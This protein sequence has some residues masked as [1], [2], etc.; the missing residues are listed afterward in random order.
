MSD[1]YQITAAECASK[2]DQSDL[3]TELEKFKQIGCQQRH[4]SSNL[5]APTPLRDF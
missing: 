2:A 3:V 5:E 4:G 1:D